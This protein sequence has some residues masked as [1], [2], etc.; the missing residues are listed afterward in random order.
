M[1]YYESVKTLKR[2][3]DYKNYLSL[4]L[5]KKL[6]SNYK[7]CICNKYSVKLLYKCWFS[8][9]FYKTYIKF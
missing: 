6:E 8:Y 4:M 1:M 9:N 2:N 7:I 5:S 3:C